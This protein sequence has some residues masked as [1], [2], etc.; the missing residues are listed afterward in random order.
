MKESMRKWLGYVLWGITFLCIFL[1][2]CATVLLFISNYRAAQLTA[3]DIPDLR[4]PAHID[5]WIAIAV[6]SLT[7]LLCMAGTW[8]LDRKRA[9]GLPDGE[10][11]RGQEPK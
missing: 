10:R 8:L 11:S 2:V 3:Q 6:L 9:Q 5:Y 7:G 4:D 1:M